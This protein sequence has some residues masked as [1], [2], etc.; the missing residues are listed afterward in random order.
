M[1]GMQEWVRPRPVDFFFWLEE[2]VEHLQQRADKTTGLALARASVCAVLVARACTSV[3]ETVELQRSVAVGTFLVL[4]H[5]K[6]LVEVDVLSK[7][8]VR[9]EL[10]RYA[11]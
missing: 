1:V 5:A 8:C 3:A 4:R 6:A 7:L 9:V 2:I 11:R 10:H